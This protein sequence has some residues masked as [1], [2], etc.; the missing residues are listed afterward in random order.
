MTVAAGWRS[1]LEQHLPLRAANL[2]LSYEA[3]EYERSLVLVLY[4]M[5]KLHRKRA[6]YR[7]W[8]LYRNRKLHRK[9]KY[10]V[11]EVVARVAAKLLMSK[12]VLARRTHRASR[13]S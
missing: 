3:Y 4:R 6:L 9:R 1:A 11:A 5:R 13:S 8:Q 12:L 10:L 7:K 2:A